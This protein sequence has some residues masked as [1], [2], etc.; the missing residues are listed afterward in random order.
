MDIRVDDDTV[1]LVMTR[2]EATRLG[3]ALRIGYEVTSR[4]EYYIRSGLSQPAVR[5]IAGVL[6]AGGAATVELGAGVEEV[7]NP[8]RPRPSA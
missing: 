5:A 2:D 1:S 7:E 8:R 4:P 6:I 3:F